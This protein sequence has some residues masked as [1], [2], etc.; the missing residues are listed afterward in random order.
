MASSALVGALRATL[1][2]DT[3]AFEE[4]SKRAT[5]TLGRLE[6]TFKRAFVGLSAAAALGGAAAAIQSVINKADQ[7][8]KMAQRIGIPVEQLSQ[9]EHVAKL[10]DVSLESL[11]TSVGRLSRNM[12]TAAGG[13][14]NDAT[15]A[16]QALDIAVRNTDGTLR[17]SSDVLQDLAAR[18][19]QMPDGAQK[20]ALAIQIL[21]RSGAE[22]IPL[23]NSGAAGVRELMQE[24]DR[25]G[26]TIDANTAAAA[27][28]FNDNLTRLQAILAGVTT[29]IVAELAPGLDNLLQRWT[30]N[31]TGSNV[32]KNVAMTL[33]ESMKTLIESVLSLETRLENLSTTFQAVREIMKLKV[34]IDTIS[35]AKRIWAERTKTITD[36]FAE[37]NAEMARIWQSPNNPNP[38]IAATSN[39]V[40]ILSSKVEK[41]KFHWGN[42]REV[43][44]AALTETETLSK[45]LSGVFDNFSDTLADTFLNAATGTQS[46]KDAF[47]DLADDI[48]RQLNRILL[49]RAF[50]LIFGLF[51][52]G[53]YR[54]GVGP[55]GMGF[56][57]FG[58]PRQHGGPVWPG[59]AFKVGERGPEM[60]VPR[61]HGEIV[62]HDEI[63][64]T[65]VQIFDQRG[66]GAPPI[67]HQSGGG[68]E[69]FFIRDMVRK[70]LP[71]GL[72]RNMPAQFGLPS[73]LIRRG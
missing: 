9:L 50:E 42:Y 73:Q 48:L 67:E 6:K 68:M 17:N 31:A 59:G 55:G 21:G 63:G 10:A 24:A 3:A 23:L 14:R 1:G 30:D 70:E 61:E 57:H 36:N 25:L 62:P 60:F 39:N 11:G 5:G 35:E 20:T 46:F 16:F 28:R 8:G 41:A 54:P 45:R 19:A 47:R 34:G 15:R 56:L 65:K 72:Q 32:F 7:L 22:L 38:V 12:L 2:L 66:A 64:G 69:R 27:E 58:G 13:A 29:R 52:G 71:S 26:L 43:S 53:G 51:A 37:L 4:G 18:F 49:S 40:E 44:G 33:A